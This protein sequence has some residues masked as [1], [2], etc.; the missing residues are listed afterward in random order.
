MINN[1]EQFNSQT[2]NRLVKNK[3]IKNPTFRI[4]ILLF[5]F[6][7]SFIA[8]GTQMILMVI[9]PITING[10]KKVIITNEFN[11]K[12]ITDR[13]GI[14]LATN[15]KVNSL[16]AHPSEIIDKKKVLNSL[17]KIFDETDQEIFKKKLYSKKPFVWL[18]KTISPEQQKLVKDI[19][20]PGLYFG[21]REMRIYPNGT[22][23]AHI[24]GGTRYGFESV[25]S[26]EILGIAGV[27]LFYDKKLSD[28]N[29]YLEAIQLSIDIKIQALVEEI[30]EN[31]IKLMGAKGGSVVLMD[32]KTG[33]IISLAS[34]PKFNPN[35]RPKNLFKN[36]PSNSPIFNRAVQGIYELGSVFKIFPV[37][38]GLETKI[39]T[40]DT[41]F[42]T[43]NPIRISGRTISDHKYFGPNLSVED[44][45]IKSSNI[46]TVRITQKLGSNNLKE[47]YKDLGLLDSTTLE[48]P[49]TKGTKPQQPRK[50][51]NLETA[52][53]SYGHGIAVSPIHLATAYSILV[54]G[55]FKVNPTILKKIKKIELRDQI[56]S[57]KTSKNV[58]LMLEKVVTK[59]T[60]RESDFGGYR[61]GG[62]TGTA[63]KPNPIQG[64]YY[65][66]KVISTFVSVF[67]I[68]KA[69]YVLVVTLDEPENN[70]GSESYRYASKTAVPVAAKIIS[71]IAPLLNLVKN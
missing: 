17:K 29:F 3:P 43:H 64:G 34:F 49:E 2:N 69:N 53:A 39:I 16:Y 65:E 61:V 37:A 8:I 42:N 23:A 20:Q 46:G 19:G 71:R 62:K 47:F 38:L 6:I 1:F 28:Q 54:N 18:R 56:V 4:Y 31:G 12:E 45:I 55:G 30:L 67:P 11:R 70:F 27:E 22:S 5:V 13:N 25:D 48:L 14:L 68:T 57:K 35:L 59:G 9:N 15:V 33:E 7:F 50:W 21:P 36:D 60:A 51:K 32:S 63:E 66:N 24:L 52:T 40:P 10:S 26:A 44:I 41:K 58:R